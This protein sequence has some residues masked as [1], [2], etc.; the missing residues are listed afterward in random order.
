MAKFY[1]YRNV[2]HNGAT[3]AFVLTEQQVEAKLAELHAQH[4]G[5]V[6]ERVEVRVVNR[7][8]KVWVAGSGRAGNSYQRTIT[9]AVIEEVK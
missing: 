3:R 4:P 6:F 1:S 5:V 9:R 2:T 8:R 7:A